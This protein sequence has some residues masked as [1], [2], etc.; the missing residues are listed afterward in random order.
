[1]VEIADELI[2][3]IEILSKLQLDQNERKQAKI[4]MEKMLGYIDVLGKVDTEDVKCAIHF[5]DEVNVFR[6]DEV[7]EYDEIDMIVNSAP[8]FNEGM[9]GVPKTL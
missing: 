3:K 1:M 6:E 7:V 9:F 4:D 8:E 2:D 5:N